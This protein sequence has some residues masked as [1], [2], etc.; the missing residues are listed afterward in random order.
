VPL[1]LGGSL[2]LF[3]P[4]LIATATATVV[5]VPRVFLLFVHPAVY[6]THDKDHK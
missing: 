1:T 3:N 2:K 4:L 6:S 5:A